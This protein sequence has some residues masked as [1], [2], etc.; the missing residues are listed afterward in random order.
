[1]SS[2]FYT[3]TSVNS[4]LTNSYYTQISQNSILSS[5][6]YTQSQTNLLLSGNYYNQT[7]INTLL[8][9][10]QNFI[11]T[12]S[13]LAISN[14]TASTT[15]NIGNASGT[16]ASLLVKGSATTA[17]IAITGTT[18]TN[19]TM[20]LMSA[21]GHNQIT[22]QTR[23]GTTSVYNLA[24]IPMISQFTATNNPT[25]DLGPAT[26]KAVIPQKAG[27]TDL[28]TW[29]YGLSVT[30]VSSIYSGLVVHDGTQNCISVDGI[31]ALIVSNIQNIYTNLKAAGVAGFTTY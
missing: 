28:G 29:N 18:G 26:L 7:T 24:I 6:Y 14:F 13:N 22:A 20:Q 12:N 17:S 10:K 25:V 9:N 4:I 21:S 15:M 19:R 31:L 11:S 5:Q 1:L 3:Q 16:V 2:L 23:N 27:N 30:S 8:G